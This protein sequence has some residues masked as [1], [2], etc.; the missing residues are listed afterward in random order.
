MICC[1]ADDM[2]LYLSVKRSKPLFWAMVR[3]AKFAKNICPIYCRSKQ[4]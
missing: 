2:Q 3:I 1:Y 4:T